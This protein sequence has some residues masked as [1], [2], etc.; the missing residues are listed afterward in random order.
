MKQK[1]FTLLTLL[2]LCVTG[3]WADEITI[4]WLNNMTEAGT[5]EPSMAGVA[6][7]DGIVTVNDMTY[8]AT[9][10]FQKTEAQS[11]IYWANYQSSTEGTTKNYFSINDY[12]ECSI[13]IP[14]GYNFTPT[15]VTAL[16]GAAGTGN[17]GAKLFEQGTF[18]VAD[19]KNTIKKASEGGTALSVTPVTKT[20][21]NE[22]YKVRVYFGQNSKQNNIRN[23][24]ITGTYAVA[25]TDPFISADDVNISASATGGNIAYTI[26]NPVV[27]GEV[28]AAKQGEADW[29][30]SVGN[31]DSP[32]AFTTEAN[33][34]AER[35]A[36]VRLTYTYNTSETVTKDV[37]ITQAAKTY[38]ITYNPGT[39]G[40]GSIDAGEKAYGVAFTLSSETFTRALYE[41]TG[42]ATTDGGAKVYELGGSY[43]AN[44]DIELFPVWEEALYTVTYNVNGGGS[45]AT[46][47]ATQAS[48][49]AALT[50]PTPTW[51]GYTFDGWYNAGTKIGDAGAS[52]T[53]TTNITLYAKWTDNIEGKLF[54]YVDGN[55]GDKFQA[56]DASGSVTANG[57]NKS[58]TF[59]DGTTGAQF[60]VENGAWDKKDNSIS[61]LAKLVKGT[62]TMS[63]VIP[64]GYLATVKI[65]Y[66]AYGTGDDYKMTVNG[67]DQAAASAKFDDGHTNAQVAS[68]MR[69]VILN[70]QSGTLNLSVHGNKN[71]Y[72]ARVAVVLTHVTGTITASGWNTFSS[73]HALDLSNVTNGTAY[74]ASAA[75]GTTVT[76]TPVDDKIVAAGTGLMIKGTAGDEFAIGMTDE[77]A[78]FSGTNKLEGLPTGGTVAKDN[79]N[80][81]FGW[82]DPADPGF[83]LVNATEPVL[84]AG[85]A[86][87]HADNDLTVGA[88]LSIDFGESDVT[89][90]NKVEAAKQ[91]VG[92]YYNL[93]GQRVAQPTKGLYIV[94]GKK[95]VL[96]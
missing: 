68:D 8:T 9:L 38:A 46:T 66:G 31:G 41:Q 69:D 36:T 76:L 23:V 70:N 74:V 32:I 7:V 43:T 50:L 25:S 51:A 2:V 73:S 18:P 40:T 48:W 63:I 95:V 87:L 10:T 60:V 4:T 30:L 28:T 67:T 14:A 39:Y 96:K 75:E 54:S 24:I 1:V 65:L 20:Y 11:G 86:Y 5:T 49:G 33:T 79:H 59:T 55:F 52:Y 82:S 13:T 12:F 3:A 35:S 26:T 42:W 19:A 89:A 16:V 34:G 71:I 72:I 80:Y 37:T 84:P 15:S 45:C 27:G 83:Y 57:S 91:N 17:N 58:K 6:S 77:A 47:S 85:K 64:A 56:F 62:S 53:P 90:I 92:E 88:R 22:T 29:L 94:N 78:T 21:N 44:A 93:A 61:A 81:V